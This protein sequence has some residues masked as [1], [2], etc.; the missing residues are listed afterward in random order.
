MR[1]LV[2]KILVGAVSL[3]PICAVA[4]DTKVSAY[5]LASQPAE[6]NE[7]TPSSLY[8]SVSENLEAYLLTQNISRNFW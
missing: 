6:T 4:D 1:R 5:L 2:Y 8:K 7:E 3:A